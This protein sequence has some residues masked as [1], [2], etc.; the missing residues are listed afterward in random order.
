MK[1]DEL[2]FSVNHNYREGYEDGYADGK[3]ERGTVSI[4]EL[5]E[6]LECSCSSSPMMECKNCKFNT[7]EYIGV[8]SASYD[9]IAPDEV[10][11]DGT[12]VF[13][14]CDTERMT[15]D[16]A[17]ALKDLIGGLDDGR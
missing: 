12:K 15:K 2:A 11:E 8:E 17:T 16:A 13:R 9:Y 4:L 1:K 3:N 6:A 7:T 5:I 14:I 10:L